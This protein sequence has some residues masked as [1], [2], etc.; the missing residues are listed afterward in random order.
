MEPIERYDLQA[1]LD[2]ELI[3][4]S[5]QVTPAANDIL[6]GIQPILPGCDFF[7]LAPTMFKKQKRSVRLEDSSNFL[8]C[9]DRIGNCTESPGADGEIK[10]SVVIRQR[11]SGDMLNANGKGLAGAACHNDLRK[12]VGWVDGM[13][14]GDGLGV[15]RQ[16]QSGS[17]SQFQ[18]FTTDMT[19]QFRT[20]A[21]EF[22]SRHD[23]VHEAGENLRGIQSHRSFV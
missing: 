4:S 15:V 16:I 10:G 22:V 23:P 2:D 9:L 20:Q 11:L 5:V 17:Y 19:K 18:H 12:K 21:M 6:D 1:G 14:P 8:E 7:I 3:D 13:K